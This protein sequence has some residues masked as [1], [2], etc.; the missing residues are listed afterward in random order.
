MINV[1]ITGDSIAPGKKRVTTFELEY[2]RMIHSELMTHR[3]FVRNAASSRAIPIDRMIDQV[4]ANTAFP[5]WTKNQKGMQG[6]VVTDGSLIHRANAIWLAAAA[7][8]IHHVWQLNE[9]GIHKQDANRLLEPFQ[10]IKTVV[11]ATEWDGWDLQR[12]DGAAALWIQALSKEM[13]RQRVTGIPRMLAD[14][15]WHLPG[16]TDEQREKYSLEEL[17]AISTSLCAQVS[18]RREDA[19]LEKAQDI[20]NNKLLASDILH[21]HPSSISAVL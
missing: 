7:N 19:S 20:L 2:P 9:L 1:K 21:A 6:E 17:K 12:T 5:I 4:E 10:H 16:I 14:G 8:M 11:T 13:Q 15:E 18:Y 3:V